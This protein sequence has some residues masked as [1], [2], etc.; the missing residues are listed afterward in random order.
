MLD[1]FQEGRSHM[2]VVS[3]MSYE[4]AASVK[5]EVKK[6]LTRRLKER[7][8]MGDSSSSESSDDEVDVDATASTDGSSQEGTLNGGHSKK[9]KWGRRRKS[10]KK[11]NKNLDLEKG[12]GQTEKSSEGDPDK[13]PV[14]TTWEKISIAGREQSMPDDAVLLKDGAEEVRCHSAH[15]V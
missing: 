7:V 11:S 3:R 4:K 9:R 6:G 10:K 12:D 14:K 8:G 15:E 1:K 5:Q 2:A 13:V